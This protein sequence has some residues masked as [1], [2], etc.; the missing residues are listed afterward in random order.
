[1]LNNT[2]LNINV[3]GM[4]FV[5]L[6]TALGL[7]KKGFSVHGIEINK[8]ILNN[9]KK[10]KIHFSEQFLQ[11]NLTYFL[12]KKKISFHNK[13]K[14][15]KKLN[16][17]LICLGTPSKANGELDLKQIYNF[18]K[19]I[20]Y[21]KKNQYLMILK[22]TVLPGT[23]DKIIKNIFN[24]NK[25]FLF[26]SNP[27][28]LREGSAWKDFI[29]ADKILIGYQNK[30][31]KKILSF[32]YKNFKSKIFYT[33]YNTAE[34]TK[35]LS[36]TFLS[37]LISFSNFMSMIASSTPNLDI[38][39]SFEIAKTDSRWNGKP[40][41]MSAY[42]HPG[43]GY[44][45]YC[46]PK[47]I[48]A[49]CFYAKN[50]INNINL[51][52]NIDKINEQTTKKTF[53]Q[54]KTYLQKNKFGRINLLGLSFKPFSDDTRNSKSTELFNLLKELNIPMTLCD[55]ITKYITIKKKKYYISNKKIKFKKDNYYILAT[56]WPEYINFLKKIP[57]KNL[58]DTRFII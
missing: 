18:C 52:E 20:S 44:G 27:E 4:G 2:D 24:N 36:N 15:S 33:N 14:I 19:K 45:G 58:F 12:K 29:N 11:E 17:I 43:L 30:K 10:K 6:T 3:I 5:G 8:L 57:K 39:K 49:F 7:C 32:L 13:I 55:P 53:E 48:K 28:F 16:I 31:V 21:D 34:F 47:D 9:L 41:D 1:M 26:C 22:S 40:C 25:N 51:I 50:K 42:F 54:I 46:L 38:K 35:Y 23:L 56:A 37:N